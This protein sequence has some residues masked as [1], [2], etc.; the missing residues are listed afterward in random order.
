MPDISS[1]ALDPAVR[2][3]AVMSATV[4]AGYR[5]FRVSRGRARCRCPRPGSPRTGPGSVVQAPIGVVLLVPWKSLEPV[6]IRSRSAARPRRCGRSSG[7]VV[8][9]VDL[10]PQQAGLGHRRDRGVAD[11]PAA[12]GGQPVGEHRHPA[13]RADQR[14]ALPDVGVDLG[15]VVRAAVVQQRQ[16]RV[17]DRVDDARLHQG[18]G[19]VRAADDAAVGA[20]DDPRPTTPGSRPR[21][22]P[23][24]SARRAPAAR[25]A[26]ARAR[27]R[28]PGWVGSNR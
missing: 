26:A 7:G 9:V 16:E 8:G 17:V 12:L 6:T 11:D 19:D 27:R 10:Q 1:W 24:R 2:P 13:G 18:A 23:R 25:R 22:A 15:D 3:P 14:D 28:S 20:L 5:R 21:P 4:T